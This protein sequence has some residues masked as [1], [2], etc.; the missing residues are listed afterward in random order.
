MRLGRC[1]WC[2]GTY[3]WRWL[4]MPGG[5]GVAAL[6][7]G[8]T[9]AD[10]PSI[11]RFRSNCSEMDVEPIG[12]T[13]KKPTRA[14]PADQ[15]VRPTNSLQNCPDNSWTLHGS[16]QANRLPHLSRMNSYA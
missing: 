8:T 6:I 2:S 1:F 10:T 15:G 7:A 4:G 11:S 12:L 16:R 9:S 5:G 14:S 3:R 13:D